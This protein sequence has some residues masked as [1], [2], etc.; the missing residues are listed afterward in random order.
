MPAGAPP[1]RPRPLPPRPPVA[2]EPVPRLSERFKAQ[3][4]KRPGWLAA[5]C[6]A[7]VAGPLL[8]LSTAG[9]SSTPPPPPLTPVV[10]TPEPPIAS[11]GPQAAAWLATAREAAATCPGLPPEVLVA[12]GHVETRLGDGTVPSSAGAVGPMQFLPSTWEAYGADGNG[13]GRADV[14]NRVD[15]LHGAARLL[16][17]NGGGEPSGLRRALWYYNRSPFYVDE[18]L[19][20]AG[21]DAP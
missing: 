15:A 8:L 20:L 7:T 3:V 5:A 17:A 18:V 2:P 21:V 4:R 16:C 14:M 12:I 11:L 6:L 13:D 19:R 1:F 9:A 10:S